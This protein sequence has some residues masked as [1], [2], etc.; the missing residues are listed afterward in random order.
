MEVLSKPATFLRKPM[1]FSNM[2]AWGMNTRSAC[3]M[4]AVN[5]NFLWPVTPP[6]LLLLALAKE[7]GWQGNPA[8]NKSKSPC[9]GWH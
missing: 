7:Y 5:P 8:T 2:K 9:G 3:T 1:T 4:A 6:G